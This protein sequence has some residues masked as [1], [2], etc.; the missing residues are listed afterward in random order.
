[1]ELD[2]QVF[3]AMNN[4][5]AEGKTWQWLWA[6]TNNRLFDLVTAA[7]MLALFG[8]YSLYRDRQNLNR[9]IAIGILL[10]LTAIIVSQIGKSLPIKR[11]SGTLIYEEA[12]RLSKLVPEIF[13]KDT[14]SDT[15]PGDHGLLLL[16][17]TGFVSFY[18]PRIYGII[19]FAMMIIFT[20][21]RLVGGS[22]WLTDEVVGAASV[23]FASLSWILAT[24]LHSIAINKLESWI[25]R[26]RKQKAS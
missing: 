12:L 21:P 24:P 5:L 20:M 13:T 10:L 8:H 1:M 6:I 22:H 26:L 19:A 2:N 9:Y 23:G 16:L 17:F 25:I 14:A 11:P 3:W 18:M 4:S 15:F 7:C